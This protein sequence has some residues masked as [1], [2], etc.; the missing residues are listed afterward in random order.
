MINWWISL[1]SLVS[2]LFNYVWSYFFH[3]RPTPCIKLFLP[4]SP[5]APKI[6]YNK[7]KRTGRNVT[8]TWTRPQHNNC[9]I[10]MYS[11]QYRETE[12]TT[13]NWKQINTTNSEIIDY[14]M[15]LQYSRKYEVIVYAWNKLGRSTG[16]DVWEVR[17]EQGTIPVYCRLIEL[18]RLLHG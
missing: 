16:S 11:V 15:R 18:F 1:I 8:V 6:L 12:P 14:E 5:D 9:N 10:T 4:G 7:S 2:L 3:A 13:E 17:T